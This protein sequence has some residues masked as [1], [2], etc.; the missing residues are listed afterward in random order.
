MTERPRAD[1]TGFEPIAY[2]VAA[3]V[4]NSIASAVV[5]SAM[6]PR[7][8]ALIV[9]KGST[10]RLKNK[11]IPSVEITE[12]DIKAFS[13][14]VLKVIEPLRHA[15]FAQLESF[16]VEAALEAVGTS[17]A[18]TTADIFECD[19]EVE[20]Y[21]DKVVD[22]SRALLAKVSLS[23]PGYHF[24]LRA[25]SEVSAQMLNFITT[26]PSFLAR[27]D[28]EQLRRMT[29]LAKDLD[30]IRRAVIENASAEESRFEEKYA[31]VVIN[32]LDHLELFG[33]T[34]SDPGRRVYPLSTAYISLSVAE[35]ATPREKG[36]DFGADLTALENGEAWRGDKEI[37]AEASGGIRAETAVSTFPRILLRGD[38]GSGK[39]TLLQWLAVNVARRSLTGELQRFNGFVP[40]ILPLR[41][42]ADRALPAAHEFLSEIG[43][44]IAGGMPD[45]WVNRVLNSGS[46]F[47]LIDG[48]DELPEMRREEAR[49]WLGD[50]LAAYPEAHYIV[51]SR[52]AAAEEE[53]LVRYGFSSV[54]MLPMSSLDI[55]NFVHH[56]HD[57]ARLCMGAEAE[58]EEY[59]ELLA[60]ESELTKAI[61]SQSQLRKL[62]SNPLLCAL[63]CTLS[64]DR[65]MQLPE[66]RMEL[67]SAA[68]EMLLVRRDVERRIKHQGVPSL[69][70]NQKQ[71]IL[72][73]FAY[74]LLRNQL[75][76]STEEEA[77]G[78]VRIAL[79]S[80]P[81]VESGGERV[82][83]YLMVRSGI[84]RQPVEGRVDFIH[85]TFQEYLAAAN[86]IALN[87]IGSLIQNAHLDQWNEVVSMAVGHARKEECSQILK[88]LIDRGNAEPENTA[89]LHLLAA[90]CLEN[91]DEVDRET[92][93][94]V[95]GCAAEL[96]PPSKVSEAKELAR[97][98]E[99]VLPL[100]P[101]SGRQLLAQ[102]AA[103]TVRTASLIGGEA[104]LDVLSGFGADNRKSVYI[105]LAR[106]WTQFDVHAFAERVMVKSPFAR[107]GLTIDHPE[108]LPTI[109]HFPEL[110]NLKIGCPV[111][112]FEWVDHCRNLTRLSM[113]GDFSS[114]PERIVQLRNLSYLSVTHVEPDADWLQLLTELP[115]LVSLSIRSARGR[116]W[117]V[118]NLPILPSLGTLQLSGGDVNF[119]SASD[120]IPNI[121]VL[122]VVSSES[123]DFS[124]L[125]SLP[126]LRMLQLGYV[127]AIRNASA[128][129]GSERL[130]VRALSCRIEDL[131]ELAKIEGVGRLSI[132][133]RSGA[134]GQ[135]IDLSPFRGKKGVDIRVS[136]PATIY[137]STEELGSGVA[138]LT[139]YVH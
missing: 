95:R 30:N 113:R 134:E 20:R 82:Y 9:S 116:E 76:D 99:S 127:N 132:G 98:G 133:L 77:I 19:L 42:Y 81:A 43:K 54:D 22:D 31:E 139:R 70:L 108:L 17:F 125:S 65:R 41:R 130:S 94:L 2:K 97:I 117:S 128:V 96:I 131:P 137:P 121:E 100:L 55:D 115:N 32:K 48:V 90:A 52:P 60:Y 35:T 12:K 75:T 38:A 87:D 74:W 112:D 7:A 111:D 64:R 80:M 14:H 8:G 34:V 4:L 92:F 13:R 135:R 68:L 53:W 45:R 28:I 89:K 73:H 105:E 126:R 88:G 72:G 23:D 79:Q 85:R 119:K 78:Q 102:K 124:A 49:E 61:R 5:R 58:D 67:Y 50:L 39:T 51:T 66:G 104:A 63:L 16:E 59:E 44:H 118:S 10:G 136:S 25:V 3:G 26:W 129:N 27:A 57:A 46:A 93:N 86:I 24:Y 37:A 47:V 84:L 40:F 91:A 120:V 83:K 107:R 18:A 36:D 138:V 69:T 114:A 21:S 33:V 1:V 110:S 11:F 15:E 109:R 29:K 56:W 6:T 101:R 123:V 103:S 71:R 62:A 106:A 122:T